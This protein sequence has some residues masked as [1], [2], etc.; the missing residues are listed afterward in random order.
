MRF[1][2]EEVI[3][4]AAHQESARTMQNK[5]EDYGKVSNWLKNTSSLC[6]GCF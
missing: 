5:D 3:K 1:L 4:S 6:R 2:T